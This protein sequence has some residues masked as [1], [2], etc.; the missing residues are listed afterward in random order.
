VVHAYEVLPPIGA[1]R[2][3]LYKMGPKAVLGEYV[4]GVLVERPA[5]DR[6]PAILHEAREMLREHRRTRADGQG[7]EIEGAWS[8]LEQLGLDGSLALDEG[9]GDR[10][11]VKRTPMDETLRRAYLRRLASDQE[12]FTEPY[13]LKIV[14]NLL[15]SGDYDGAV[16]FDPGVD[17]NW[18]VTSYMF[19]VPGE[20]VISWRGLE[21]F[22]GP[23]ASNDLKITVVPTV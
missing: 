20:H 21:N 19:D 11:D 18:E 3:S 10:D 5:S 16:E 2:M 13:F 7:I 22:A 1:R 15:G 4:D 23:A 9:D 14:S 8:I 6:D 12:R 17:T